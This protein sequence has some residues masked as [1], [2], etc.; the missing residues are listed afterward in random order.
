MTVTPLR[1]LV[2]A[3]KSSISTRIFIETTTATNTMASTQGSLQSTRFS[4]NN[5]VA[6]SGDPVVRRSKR[7]KAGTCYTEASTEED[8][9]S[10]N[11]H[12]CA[13]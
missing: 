9:H 10:G 11:K 13:V 12:F 5:G 2:L 4:T 3:E 8:I 1:F 7:Q 6:S